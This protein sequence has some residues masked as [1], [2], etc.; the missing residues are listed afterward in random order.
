MQGC[1]R[2]TTHHATRARLLAGSVSIDDTSTMWAPLLLPLLPL[3][4][5]LTASI[6]FTTPCA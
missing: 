4:L 2:A 5:L 6:T 3:L 1:V